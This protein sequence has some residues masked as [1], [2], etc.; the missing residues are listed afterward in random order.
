MEMISRKPRDDDELHTDIAKVEGVINNRPLK[1]IRSGQANIS[2][3][4]FLWPTTEVDTKGNILDLLNKRK[5]TL[6]NYWQDS[7]LLELQKRRFWHS[8]GEHPQIR[9]VVV[10][11]DVQERLLHGVIDLCED[12]RYP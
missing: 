7:Y 9:D 12:D 3:A 11:V 2:P 8:D 1:E 4:D 6:T 5:N 10:L